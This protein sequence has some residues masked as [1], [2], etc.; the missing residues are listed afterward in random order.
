[1]TKLFGSLLMAY[2]LFWSAFSA[3]GQSS[4]N[5]QVVQ[6]WLTEAG[7]A[8]FYLQGVITERGDPSERI[9]VDMSWLGPEKWKRTIKSPEFSQ[10]LVVNGDKVFEQDSADYMPLAIQ[11]LTTAMVDPRP[12]VAAVRPADPVITK[13][14]GRAAENGKICFDTAGKMCAMS[15]NG[16][17][18][19]LDAPGRSVTFTDYRKFKNKRVA[20][21][22]SYKVDH[23]DSYELRINTLGELKS[24]GSAFLIQEPTPR[25]KQ[26]RNVV[27]PEEELGRSALES[28]E[29][30]WPQVL[31]DQRTKGE[32]SYYVSVDRVG[33]F[34]E[35]LPLSVSIERANDSARRQI[36]KWKFRPALRD[37]LPVQAESVVNLH[38]DTRAYGPPSPLT[39]TEVRKLATNITDPNFPS[40]SKT[41]D[42][43]SVRIAV[44]A[45][46]KVIELIAVSG[47]YELAKPCMDSIGK[48]H[49]APIME[50]GQPR[51]YRA[52][53]TC[54]VP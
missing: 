23:G 17:T 53:V 20:R 35:I 45:D 42:S 6:A 44:D 50:N 22:L 28:T 12:I 19:I 8:P 18:E 46:G 41:G 39:D 30:I 47:P 43:T 21:L 16:L 48:W 2:V 37:G 7:S 34:R 15:R 25:E 33:H 51:P 31:E 1:M 32:T 10:T 26:I 54:R 52:E 4:S 13:A 36:M 27:V 3:H 29:I 38:F 11:V 49:L 24:D 14:N 5:A 40:D 9:D